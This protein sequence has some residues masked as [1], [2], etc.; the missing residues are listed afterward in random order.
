VRALGLA[1]F[2]LVA[3]SAEAVSPRAYVSVNGNDA[4]TCNVPATP[5]RTFTGAIAQVTS[6]GEVVVLDSGTFGGGTISQSVTI[7]APE[8]VAALA[9]TPITVN[10]GASDVVTLRGISFVSPSPGTGVALTFNGGA[11]LNVEGC[12]FHG[13]STGLAFTVAGELHVTDTTFRENA[14]TG[15]SLQAPSGTLLASLERLRLLGNATG[16]TVYDR[17]KATIK[18][19]LIAGNTNKGLYAGAG[20][21]STSELDIENCLITHNVDGAA[22]NSSVSGGYGIIRIAR[23]TVTGNTNRGLAEQNSS[24]VYSRG[25]NTIEANNIDTSGTIGSFV[26]K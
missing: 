12:V 20:D 23:S 4:N 25:N 14:Y 10:A 24:F 11:V 3:T 15:L 26:G 7:N 19:S 5:C 6:G 1:G 17:S 16:L 9:A 21:D 22:T 18:N 8:G 13:W 2:W